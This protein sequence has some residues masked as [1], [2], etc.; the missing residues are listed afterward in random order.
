MED[1]TEV[2]EIIKKEL[3]GNSAVEKRK[4]QKQKWE[5]R[6]RGSIVDLRW[7]KEEPANFEDEQKVCN[8]KN[9]KKKKKSKEK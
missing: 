7:Q 8:Q 5:V 4:T 3:N 2:V 9:R 6:Q 1:I